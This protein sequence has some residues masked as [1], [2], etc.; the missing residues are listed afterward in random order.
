MPPDPDNVTSCLW[1]SLSPS[2]HPPIIVLRGT[3]CLGGFGV[4]RQHKVCRFPGSGGIDNPLPSPS[5]SF[6]ICVIL[7]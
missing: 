6:L 7:P 4:N 5:S 3:L 1:C 2:Y